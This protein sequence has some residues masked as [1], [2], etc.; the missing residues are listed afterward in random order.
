MTC[1]AALFY[2]IAHSLMSNVTSTVA[3]TVVGEMKIILVLLLS[4]LLLGGWRKDLRFDLEVN[5]ST[6]KSGDRVH[7]TS[8]LLNRSHAFTL[9]DA[10][11]A[12]TFAVSARYPQPGLALPE[13]LS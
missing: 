3:T 11:P 7:Y 12:H 4:A 9:L 8:H 2:S 10:P 1:A 5:K 13:S 6:F